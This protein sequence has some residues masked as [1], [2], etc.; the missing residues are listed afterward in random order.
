M[1]PQ[2]RD[3]KSLNTAEYTPNPNQCHW[4]SAV[5]GKTSLKSTNENP[6][7]TQINVQYSQYLHGVFHPKTASAAFHWFAFH[8]FSRRV[9]I[10]LMPC[11]DAT[12]I[13]WSKALSRPRSLITSLICSLCRETRTVINFKKKGEIMLTLQS[14]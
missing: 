2:E 11:S 12:A 8:L 13:T 6:S 4:I 1:P 5:D 9:F 10:S 14:H 3:Y 7:A